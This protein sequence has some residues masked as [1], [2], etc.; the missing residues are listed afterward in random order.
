MSEERTPEINIFKEPN[1][2]GYNW[3][4]LF[5]GEINTGT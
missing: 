4:T 2:Q 3:A 1:A 5:L